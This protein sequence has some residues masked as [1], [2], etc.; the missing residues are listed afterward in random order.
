M[1]QKEDRLTWAA[2]WTWCVWNALQKR[3][4]DITTLKRR[5]PLHQR[6]LS[7][8]HVTLPLLV[9]RGRVGGSLTMNLY[10]HPLPHIWLLLTSVHQVRADMVHLSLWTGTVK[11]I[12]ICGFIKMAGKNINPKKKKT[13]T[14]NHFDNCSSLLWM[15]LVINLWPALKER[16][17]KYQL[18]LAQEVSL[19]AISPWATWYKQTEALTMF[20]V[21][22][23]Q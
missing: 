13:L 10:L 21:A 5:A 14:L 4:E 3:E 9:Y 7:S 18:A 15:T 19:R 11:Q 1:K 16:V 20:T 8:P 2:P 23:R 17:K 22:L 6:L 12:C